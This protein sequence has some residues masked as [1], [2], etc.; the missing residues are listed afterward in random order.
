[1]REYLYWVYAEIVTPSEC[2]LKITAWDIDNDVF[3]LLEE[4]I[5]FE[6]EYGR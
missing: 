3:H 4:D 5:F 6:P 2:H 1:M